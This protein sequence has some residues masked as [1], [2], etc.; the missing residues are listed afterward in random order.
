RA[1][2]H[3]VLSPQVQRARGCRE[4]SSTCETARVQVSACYGLRLA[5]SAKL[6]AGQ[7]Q[8]ELDKCQ[9]PNG[10]Q[11]NHSIY[12]S[13]RTV[14]SGRRRSYSAESQDRAVTPGEVSGGCQCPGIALP[15]SSCLCNIGPSRLEKK[16][17]HSRHC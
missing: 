4:S 7:L 13:W 9:F 6:V 12:S 1:G 16:R 10:S 5:N 15:Q 2:S 14:Y 11:G 8:N 17:R 3:R